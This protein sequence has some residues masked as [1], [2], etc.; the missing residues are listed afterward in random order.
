MTVRREIVEPHRETGVRGPEAPIRTRALQ[1]GSEDEPALRRLVG[2]H[3]VASCNLT[4]AAIFLFKVGLVH[5]Y[6][7]A[8]IT[9]HK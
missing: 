6:V 3:G 4:L 5:P 8:S 7:R 9:H 2:T 1:G